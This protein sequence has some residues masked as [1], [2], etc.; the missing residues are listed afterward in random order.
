MTASSPAVARGLQRIS[1]PTGALLVV[2]LR[3][4]EGEN[5]EDDDRGRQVLSCLSPWAS[6]VILPASDLGDR[7]LGLEAVPRSVGVIRPLGPSGSARHR[8]GADALLGVAQPGQSRPDN[9]WAGP[10]VVAL[11]DDD[12]VADSQ[13][14]DAGDAALVMVESR[15]TTPNWTEIDASL[16]VPWVVSTG[17]RTFPEALARCQHAVTSGASGVVV[18]SELWDDLFVEPSAQSALDALDE[19]RARIVNLLGAIRSGMG[20]W[21]LENSVPADTGTWFGGRSFIYH[22]D[23]DRYEERIVLI[24][25]ADED[26]ALAACMAEADDYATANHGRALELVQVSPITPDLAAPEGDLIAWQEVF[27]QFHVASSPAAFLD[28]FFAAHGD[29]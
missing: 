12:I 8:D 4:L 6:A 1:A 11:G 26:A 29:R 10:T 14:I 18:G 28:R 5:D 19:L 21:D 15:S 25:A 17:S 20:T 3:S 13:A 2:D 24:P 16:A 22:E 27:T 9:G 7:W 23:I